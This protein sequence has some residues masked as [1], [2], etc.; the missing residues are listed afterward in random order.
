MRYWVVR[1]TTIQFGKEVWCHYGI[2]ARSVRDAIV[3]FKPLMGGHISVVGCAVNGR[4]H[5]FLPRTA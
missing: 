3:R 5:Y 1:E 2:L 4:D